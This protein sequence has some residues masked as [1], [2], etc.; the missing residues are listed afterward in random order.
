[1]NLRPGSVV[2]SVST[3]KQPVPPSPSPER[4]GVLG[5]LVEM[6][7][8]LSAD[9]LRVSVDGL[10]ASGKT[11]LGDELAHGLA[12]RGRTALRAS[13][14]DFKRPWSEAHRY[15]RTSGEGYYRNAFDFDAARRLLLDPSDPAADGVV[16]LCGLDPL[17]QVDR[18]EVKSVMPANGVLIVDGVFACRPELNRYWDLRIWVEIDPELSVRRGAQRDATMEGS[19]EQAEALHRERYLVSEQLYVDEVDPCSIVEV[20]VDNSDFDRP[21]LVRPNVFG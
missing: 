14:D 11:S 4:A 18:S 10:S 1:M 2:F 5:R 8:A 15:D 17:T 7:D 13:L 16:A 19:S 20:I 12:D 6:I 9:R 3:W 21:R